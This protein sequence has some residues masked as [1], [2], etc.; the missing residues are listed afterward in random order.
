MICLYV[1]VGVGAIMYAVQFPT[2]AVPKALEKYKQES[3]MGEKDL[4]GPIY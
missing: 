1:C 3:S 2:K 4:T